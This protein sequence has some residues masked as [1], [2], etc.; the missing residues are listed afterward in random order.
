MELRTLPLMLLLISNIHPGQT[1][2]RLKA[3]VKTEPGIHETVTV[4]CEI[5]GDADDWTYSWFRDG[6]SRPFSSDRE[7][8]FETG[9]SHRRSSVTCRGERRSDG[10]KSEISDAVKLNLCESDPL[11]CRNKLH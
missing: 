11:H 1:Q 8:S 9:V 2:E 6:S 7:F 4:R 5:P 3:V 10:Q